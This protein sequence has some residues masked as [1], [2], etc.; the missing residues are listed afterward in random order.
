M[1]NSL[2]LDTLALIET[3]F[4]KVTKSFRSDNA[5]GLKFIDFFNAIG[6]NSPILLCG[7]TITL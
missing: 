2:F 3:Q 1:L 5:Q 4:H 6:G 7:E